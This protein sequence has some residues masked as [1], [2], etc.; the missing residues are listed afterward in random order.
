[1]LDLTP[2]SEKPQQPAD[3]TLEFGTC[4]AP[5]YHTL[6]SLMGR[7]GD[8]AIFRKFSSLNTLNLMRLQAELLELEEQYKI[9]LFQHHKTDGGVALASCFKAL[10]SSKSKQKDLLDQIGVKLDVYSKTD[11][12]PFSCPKARPDP[13]T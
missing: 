4:D 1:M 5:G 7:D 8:Y 9:A 13:K 12:I 2:A 3:L 6:A 11:F 10:Q